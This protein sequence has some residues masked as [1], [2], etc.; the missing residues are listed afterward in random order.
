MASSP[1]AGFVPEAGAG[2]LEVAAFLLLGALGSIHCLGMCGPLVSTY[3]E[4]IRSRGHDATEWASIRQHL[5]FNA[6]RTVSYA[7]LGAGFGALGAIL[8]DAGGLLSVARLV[9]GVVGITVG[10]FVLALG[11]GY[12]A[13]DRGGGRFVGA[14]GRPFRAGGAALSGTV[15]WL[16]ARAERW[17]R[18]PRIVGLGA[19][20]GLLPCPLLYPAFLYALATASPVRGAVAL[21]AL[22]A[23]TVPMVFATGLAVG[24]LGPE[25]KRR[26][27]RALGAAFVLLAVLPLRMGLRSLGIEPLA[28]LGVA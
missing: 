8:V 22:G 10:L 15:A 28:L 23:G 25:T 3:A 24:S 1:F 6:G 13:A 4:G 7:A 16:R 11:L 5:L 12:L 17:T 2:G 18:G 19:A 20:H 21:A 14:L 9:R 26:L 27:H